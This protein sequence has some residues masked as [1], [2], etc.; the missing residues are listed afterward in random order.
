MILVMLIGAATVLLFDT[1]G[2]LA[3]RRFN[4]NYASLAPGSWLIWAGAGY[5]AAPYGS[6]A[7]SGLAGGAV[8]FIEATLGWYISWLVGPGR[9]KDELT[10]RQIVCVVLMISLSGSGFGFGGGLLGRSF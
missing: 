3:S 1:V 6:Y 4:F 9:P 2:S 7:A 10:Q 5:F 8:A